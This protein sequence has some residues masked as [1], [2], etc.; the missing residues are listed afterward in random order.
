MQHFPAFPPSKALIHQRRT[1]TPRIIGIHKIPI[2]IR[3]RE[4]KTQTRIVVSSD[5]RPPTHRVA[6]IAGAIGDLCRVLHVV[7]CAGGDAG[8]EKGCCGIDHVHAIAEVGEG[9]NPAEDLVGGS[10][11]IKGVVRGG[12]VDEEVFCRAD[13]GGCAYRDCGNRWGGVVTMRAVDW[14]LEL[15]G[16]NL[17]EVVVACGLVLT[18]TGFVLLFL[19]A[20]LPPAPPPTAAAITMTATIAVMIQKVLAAR[21]IF[22]SA[23]AAGEVQVEADVLMRF[24]LSTC[25]PLLSRLLCGVQMRNTLGTAVESP[26]EVKV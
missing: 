24:C 4:P 23:D 11:R 7:C 19:L 16:D 1:I 13:R 2:A 14:E 12:A 15:D 21:P 18:D 9:A 22:T 6:D 25:T 3:R 26:P 8:V 17:F 20:R 10:S 5:C